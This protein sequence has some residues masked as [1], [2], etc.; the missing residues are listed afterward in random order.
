MKPSSSTMAAGSGPPPMARNAAATKAGASASAAASLR[1]A[2]GVPKRLRGFRRLTP[3]PEEVYEPLTLA[4]ITQYI[5]DR[6]ISLSATPIAILLTLHLWAP[7]GSDLHRWTASFYAPSYYNPQTGMYGKGPDDAYLIGS[8]VVVLTLLRACLT[9]YVA[10]PWARS[11]GMSRK[12]AIRFAEQAW[13]FA[14]YFISFGLGIK[15]F[16]E[17]KYMNNM[18]ELWTDWPLR[19]IDGTFK[20]YYLVQFACWIQQIFVLNIEERR[21]DYYQMFAHHVITCIL[22]YCSY[23]YH[24]TRVGHVL[25]CIFDLGDIL[26]P[27]AKMLK[28][29]KFQTSCDAMFGLF[30]LTWV[31]GRHYTFIGLIISASKEIMEI[32]PYGC[33]STDIHSH[34]PLNESSPS[35]SSMFLAPQQTVCFNQ[36]IKYG[37]L[38]LLW[39]L[40]GL[41]CMWFYFIMRVA[42]KVITGMGAEDNRSD[43]EMDEEV[44]EVGIEAEVGGNGELKFT[45]E[46]YAEASGSAAAGPAAGRR[47]REP[48]RD[49]FITGKHGQSQ[50]MAAQKLAE[51][52]IGC[53]GDDR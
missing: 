24:M 46:A 34:V 41:M 33:F 20:Y 12:G 16:V 37:F 22:V 14:Y 10:K 25:M 21:K 32:I 30:L 7:V 1:P 17:S 27:A 5:L 28:Y 13:S 39:S 19:E 11:Q 47:R 2:N 49:V 26:L 52:K 44:D 43:D 18:R 6:Q 42:I 15:L 38:A 8:W 29:L 31:M 50:F 51:S 40:Q 23:V 4:S 35:T 48:L 36:E 53:G 45:H 3:Q 9:D